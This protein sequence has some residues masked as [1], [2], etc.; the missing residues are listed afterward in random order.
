MCSFA[1]PPLEY[2]GDIVEGE[3]GGDGGHQAPTLGTNAVAEPFN[4]PGPEKLEVHRLL[5]NLER[6]TLLA[7]RFKMVAQTEQGLRIHHGSPQSPPI[8]ESP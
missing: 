8:S 2:P 1:R 6:I 7:Q 4:Q 3:E 5:Q